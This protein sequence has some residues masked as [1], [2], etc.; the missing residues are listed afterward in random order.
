MQYLRSGRNQYTVIL[1]CFENAGSGKSF[2]VCQVLY[3]D[4]ENAVEKVYAFADSERGIVKDLGDLSSSS[5]MARQL[6]DRGF[7]T[8]SSYKEY[9]GWLQKALAFARRPWTFS[10]KP[11][12]SKMCSDGLVH[13]STHAGTQA[14]E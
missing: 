11:W 3:L 13:S 7:K 9:F 10:I 2:T 6:R 14:L 5:S 1:A 8:T 4:A 12:R